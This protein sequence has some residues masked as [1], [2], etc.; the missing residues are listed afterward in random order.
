M[1]KFQ[2]IT[3][4]NIDDGNGPEVNDAHYTGVEVELESTGI[5]DV[6]KALK[7]AD[8]LYKHITRRSIYIDW[9]AGGESSIY[10][11]ARKNHYWLWELREIK[12]A[13]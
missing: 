7:A 5:V 3:L 8:L 1:K 4:G 9:E 2:V 6:M 11:R 12:Q 13:A 10:I